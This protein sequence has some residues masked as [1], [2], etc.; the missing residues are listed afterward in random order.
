[1]SAQDAVALPYQYDLFISYRR[2]GK[3]PEWVRDHLLP[4][5]TLYLGEELGEEPRIAFDEEVIESGD[6]WPIALAQKLGRSKALVALCSRQYFASAWCK[7]ELAHMMA[8]EKACGL[9]SLTQSGGLIVPAVIHDGEDFPGEIAAIKPYPLQNF[10]N[11]W[12]AFGSPTAEAFASAI[13]QWAPQVKSAIRRAH[14]FADKWET[15]ALEE[16]LFLFS[17]RPALLQV[18]FPSIAV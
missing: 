9:R 4:K 1:M 7:S 18:S 11:P 10:A 6:S 12:I 8:R 3:W 2:F 13:R 5:L 15:L 16:F 17:T 14:E